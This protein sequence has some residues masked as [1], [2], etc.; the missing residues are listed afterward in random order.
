MVQTILT[1]LEVSTILR[2]YLMDQRDFS[3]ARPIFE[4]ALAIFER[5]L[6]P[7]HYE[8]IPGL[9]GLSNISDAEGNFAKARALLERALAIAENL[10]PENIQDG[11]MPKQPRRFPPKPW[12]FCRG[13]AALRAGNRDP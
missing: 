8:L 4:R 11:D 6:G 5:K 10:G 7:D 1:R 2:I 13:A 9:I 3:A 12:R